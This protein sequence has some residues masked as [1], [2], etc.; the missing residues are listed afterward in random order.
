ML[1]PDIVWMSDLVS[2]CVTWSDYSVM[3][4]LVA[5]CDAEILLGLVGARLYCEM[6]ALW[7]PI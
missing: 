4:V 3:V 7:C 1:W 6:L 5:P 2:G